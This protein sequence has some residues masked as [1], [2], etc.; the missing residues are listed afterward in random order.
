MVF[1]R[2]MRRFRS[3]RRPFIRNRTLIRRNRLIKRRRRE[4]ILKLKV[5][6]HVSLT[7]STSAES[8]INLQFLPTDYTEFNQFADRFERFRL[9]RSTIHIK[10]TFNDI[11]PVDAVAP[12]VIAPWH[13]P[14]DTA[15]FSVAQVLSI[16]KHK[17]IAGFRSVRVSYV[18][19]VQDNISG[20]FFKK[21]L[22]T[23]PVGTAIQHHSGL[24][25]FP[26][27][28]APVVYD[29]KYDLYFQ[30]KKQKLAAL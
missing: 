10:P 4:P 29:I 7:T 25:A 12:Y 8:R 28:T 3:R 30:F 16:D 21:W 11:E 6:Q 20:F 9:V 27:S 26:A 18:P 1:R 23:D 2:F 19:A 17:Y 13:R 22:G 15:S 24:A 5:S 14:P